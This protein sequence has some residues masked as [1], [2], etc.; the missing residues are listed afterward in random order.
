MSSRLAAARSKLL[1][2]LS[3]LSTYA[4]LAA[5]STGPSDPSGAEPPAAS[6]EAAPIS[7]TGSPV[8]AAIAAPTPVPEPA[9]APAAPAPDAPTTDAPAPEAPTPPPADPAAALDPGGQPPATPAASP[10]VAAPAPVP[11][12]MPA[13]AIVPPERAALKPILL[14]AAAE[15]GLPPDLVLAQAWAESGW[16]DS[17]VSRAQAVGVLQLTAPTVDFVSRQL[18]R[19]DHPLDPLN[20]ADNARM[21]TRYLRHL[22]DRTDN[23]LRQALIAYN[24]GLGALRRNGPY[25]EA[26]TYADRVLALRPLFTA[27]E[28]PGPAPP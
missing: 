12:L 1:L 17:A 21:G 7:T 15:N 24:Q 23:D 26:Q 16:Q 11:P 22:L 13:D 8:P 20:P 6:G 14:R 9:P 5:A 27:G 4:G 3:V 25:P 18:L 19:L 2:F 28:K 10:A